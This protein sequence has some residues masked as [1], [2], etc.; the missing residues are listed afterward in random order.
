ME[1]YSNSKQN[2]TP[3]VKQSQSKV[4]VVEELAMEIVPEAVADETAAYEAHLSRAEIPLDEREVDLDEE[5]EGETA[6]EQQHLLDIG[7]NSSDSDE[8]S[9]DED[10][11]IDS[12]PGYRANVEPVTVSYLPLEQWT[13]E[14]PMEERL[15][16]AAGFLSKMSEY[17]CTVKVKAE[18]L[19][20]NARIHRAE[21]AAGV[22]KNARIIG[23]TV[24]GAAK[25]LEAIRAAEPFAVVVEE[26]CE[27]ME[28]TLMAV[29]AVSSLRKLELVGDHRQLPA[30]INQC[31]YSLAKQHSSLKVSLFE[32]LLEQGQGRWE[33]SQNAS[34]RRVLG[35][36][37]PK[38]RCLFSVGRAAA[39][40]SPSRR[41]HT[42]RVC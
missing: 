36:I 14:L 1:Q 33:L 29:L 8:A 16:C 35:S 42:R 31:W 5:D 30:Y 21:V 28:P 19:A 37:P 2:D 11:E 40:A 9:A 25:R 6:A 20:A 27:V 22:F 15:R 24:T 23:A 10:R 7:G 34:V 32:R 17:L 39:H 26:A 12:S 3:S 13:W 41:Y 4:E 38:K 18:P